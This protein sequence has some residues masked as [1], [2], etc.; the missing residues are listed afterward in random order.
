[1]ILGIIIISGESFQVLKNHASNQPKAALETP[2]LEITDIFYLRS[3]GFLLLRTCQ[4]P[5]AVTSPTLQQVSRKGVQCNLE[6]WVS[7]VT[8]G[9]DAY[10][11]HL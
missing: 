1:M 6:S 3:K 4:W 2:D 9:F 5:D 10:L 11:I 7:D 8:P